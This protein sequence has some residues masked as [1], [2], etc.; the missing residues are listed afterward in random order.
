MMTRYLIVMLS[1]LFG[2]LLLTPLVRW[3]GRRIGAVDLPDGGRKAHLVPVP[4]VGGVAVFGAFLIALFVGRFVPG[5]GHPHDWFGGAMRS[6]FYA[7][8]AGILLVGLVDDMFGVRARWKFLVQIAASLAMYIAG[9]GIVSV[10]NPFGAAIQLGWFSLP[11]TMF[12]FLACMNA[13]N[14]IDGLDGL[15]AGVSLFA[16]GAIFFLGVLFGNAQAAVLGA[17]LAGTLIGFLCYNFHPASIFLGDSGSYLLGFL[18]ATIALQSAM[19]SRMVFALLVPIVALG[20]PVFDTSLAIL[21]RW[22][23]SLPLSTPDRQH[24]HH[25]LRDMGFSH[26]QAV[27]AIYA[28]CLVLAAAALLVAAVNDKQAAA[29]FLTLGVLTVCTVRVMGVS[30]FSHLLKRVS[31][32]VKRN[33]RCAPCR[34]AVYMAIEK[35]KCAETAEAL[36]NAFEDAAGKVRL[37]QAELRATPPSG[38]EAHGQD[39]QFEWQAKPQAEPQ[40]PAIQWSATYPLNHGAPIEGELKVAKGAQDFAVCRMPEMIQAI[41]DAM[42]ENLA[43]I[44]AKGQSPPL[45][46][47]NQSQ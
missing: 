9:Y 19:K 32:R 15:A 5:V 29:L 36:W 31:N 12:W 47:R 14:L 46:S 28:A 27:L 16:V 39:I 17:A 25:K 13:I 24:L 20:V 8:A 30:E 44:C 35:F 43:R 38:A 18:V 41:S 2:A 42:A 11:L 22:A 45:E 26:K 40:N 6:V 7:S 4:R 23:R 37:H 21:R 34:A 10:S 33:T 3:A 1:G